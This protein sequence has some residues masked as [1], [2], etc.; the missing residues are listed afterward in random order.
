MANSLIIT[1]DELI[2][3]AGVDT[4]S[5]FV[6]GQ[7]RNS[8]SLE[9]E[10]IYS[11]YLQTYDVVTISVE[12]SS[13]GMLRVVDVMRRDYTT[14]DQGGD[15]GIRDTF[16]LS[17]SGTTGTTF[18]TTFTATTVASC[19]NYEY[20]V[21]VTTAENT[22]CEIIGA[23]GGSPVPS[24]IIEDGLIIYT[25]GYSFTGSTGSTARF[26]L[27]SRGNFNGRSST[28]AG[29]P[30][31][32][33][34]KPFDSGFFELNNY[35]I[36]FADSIPSGSSVSY[37]F[38]GWVQ[39]VQTSTNVTLYSAGAM[40]IIKNSTNYWEAIVNP[41]GWP[42]I[43]TVSSNQLNVNS[44]IWNYIICKWTPGNSL[45]LY[46]NGILV[47][48]TTTAFTTLGLL[49]NWTIGPAQYTNVSVF[50]AYYVPLTD[51]QILFNFNQLKA[52]YG[53]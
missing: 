11:T 25:N 51:D 53:Y 50:E 45:K 13:S 22:F 46:H 37:T 12:T 32:P 8:D 6:N 14:D 19:Y 15:N 38:G 40:R 20:R 43:S 49:N 16:I 39:T 4:Y 21:T 31:Q 42:D 48:T 26:W 47:G 10:G 29:Q 17:S 44:N 33:V 2:N 27:D 18:V 5:V 23:A 7:L 28:N 9:I 34:W 3:D 35:S 24:P 30:D 1:F 36:S 52:F 41:E